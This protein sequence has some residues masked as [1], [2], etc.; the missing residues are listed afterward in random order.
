MAKAKESIHQHAT[1]KDVVLRLKRAQGH[2]SKVISMIEAEENCLN[3]TQQLH[4]VVKALVE[5]KKNLIHDHIDHCL[6]EDVG[7][8]G[9]KNKIEEFKEITKYL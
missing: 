1:H 9:K 4:A 3:I 8:G 6:T 5:A 2:L 7:S